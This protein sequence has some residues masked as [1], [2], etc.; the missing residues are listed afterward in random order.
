MKKAKVVAGLIACTLTGGVA[1][2]TNITVSGL[3]DIFAGSLQKSGE[4]ARKG[5]VNSGGMTTSWWGFRGNEDLGGGLRAEFALTGF[6]RGDTGEI[7][8]FGGDNLFSRDANVGIAGGFGKVQLGRA[9]APNFLPTVL[10]NPFGDSF[11]FSPLV[12]HA[13]TP[14]GAAWPA[15]NAGDTG[16]S[17]Q[18]I[19]SSPKIGGATMNLH[20][21]F[22]EM[23]GS[24]ETNNVG[25]NLLYFNGPVGLTA[26]YHDVEMGNPNPGTTP[27]ANA[28]KT[29]F[30]GGSYNFTTAKVFA[31]YQRNRNDAVASTQ[32][33]TDKLYS[34]GLSAPVGQGSVLLAYASTKRSGTLV[35]TERKRDT[36]SVGYDYLFSKRTDL[37]TVAM[38]DK[39]TNADRELSFGVGVRHRF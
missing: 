37:Y 10:F 20:Y 7:G 28:Q 39:I 36:L 26:F 32:E 4:A 5:V 15:S 13:N 35:G 17:N 25:V 18:V 24:T 2:Q 21:Q 8:R 34:V 16:W 38:S 19:Y 30:V 31:T 11:T 14:T 23:P 9:L 1:A 29:A 6:F 27:L 22:G 12:M 3:V 33:S